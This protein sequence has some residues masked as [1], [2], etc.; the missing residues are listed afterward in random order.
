MNELLEDVPTVISPDTFKEPELVMP[1]VVIP[2]LNVCGLVHVLA[3][4]S[5]IP[6]GKLLIQDASIDLLG[7]LTEP[8][9]TV[10]PLFNVGDAFI[11]NVFAEVDPMVVSRNNAI[12]PPSTVKL[13]D[14]VCNAVHVLAFV[15][16]I[17][18]FENFVS[19]VFSCDCNPE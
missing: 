1:F 9:S 7:K 6:V 14:N 10:K 3:L 16:P 8:D 12:N 19:N 5:D 13:F 18:V 11:V 17:V 4:D 2:S 15:T